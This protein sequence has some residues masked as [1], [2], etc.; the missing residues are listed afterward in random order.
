MIL[1][2]RLGSVVTYGHTPK[3]QPKAHFML[4]VHTPTETGVE[5]DW[6]EILT[7]GE[8]VTQLQGLNL[9]KGDAARV[10]GYIHRHEE[11]KNGKTKTVE[12]VYA[13]AIQRL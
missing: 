6:R 4:G 8:R 13:V 5:T 2:G 11:V 1:S 12:E 3:G 10:I 7:F 9:V